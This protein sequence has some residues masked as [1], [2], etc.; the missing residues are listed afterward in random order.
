MKLESL[1]EYEAMRDREDREREVTLDVMMDIQDKL[2]TA[3][4]VWS[5][6]SSCFEAGAQWAIAEMMVELRKAF[7]A[8]WEFCKVNEEL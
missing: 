2:R 7:N 3:S 8:G 6:R 5:G 4:S 1:L